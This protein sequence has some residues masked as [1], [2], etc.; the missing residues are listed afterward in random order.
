ML[1]TFIIQCLIFLVLVFQR[2]FLQ[3]SWRVC[4]A[5]SAF[6]RLPAARSLS[7]PSSPAGVSVRFQR[8][9]AKEAQARYPRLSA[10]R[11][12]RRGWANGCQ[13]KTV[14]PGEKLAQAPFRE[15]LRER[16]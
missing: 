6:R 3:F 10:A 1:G 2:V 12:R 5:E 7:H 15:A 9:G 13:K 8:P 14:R 11:S 4:G 16:I